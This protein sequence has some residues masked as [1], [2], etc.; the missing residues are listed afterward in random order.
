MKSLGKVSFYSKILIYRYYI[1]K[2]YVGLI[3]DFS[4]RLCLATEQAPLV[5]FI[6]ALDRLD[7]K[8]LLY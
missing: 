1:F 6:D 8:T 5:L 3:N 4:Q 2:D 7:G